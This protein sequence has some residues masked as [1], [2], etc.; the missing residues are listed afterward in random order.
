MVI[1]VRN[2]DIRNEFAWIGLG[3][4]SGR[5]ARTNDR[6]STVNPSPE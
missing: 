6:R 5:L 4:D 3:W 1:S 2:K